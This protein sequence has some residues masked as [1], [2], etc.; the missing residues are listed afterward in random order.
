MWFVGT[1][2]CVGW[3]LVN[4]GGCRISARLA[5][6]VRPWAGGRVAGYAARGDAASASRAMKWSRSR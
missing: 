5:D 2:G 6:V 3:S 4:G 1:G